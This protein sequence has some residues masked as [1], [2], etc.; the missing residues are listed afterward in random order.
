MEF[1][2]ANE[3]KIQTNLSIEL[4]VQKEI[5]DAIK[6]GRNRVLII[7]TKIPKPILDKFRELGYNIEEASLY[8]NEFTYRINWE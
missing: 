4:Y 5:E 8:F 3:A 7:T 2:T 6:H 1:I